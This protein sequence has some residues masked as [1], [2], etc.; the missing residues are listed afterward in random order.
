VVADVAELHFV[1]PGVR[2]HQ[3]DSI[4]AVLLDE[5]EQFGAS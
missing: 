1:S 3:V 4:F 5:K 2:G